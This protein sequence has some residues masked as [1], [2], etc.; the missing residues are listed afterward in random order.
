MQYVGPEAGLTGF[1]AQL[2]DTLA[3]GPLTHIFPELS[4]PPVFHLQA[5][6]KLLYV[7][8]TV[9]RGIIHAK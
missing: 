1:K 5:G 9:R 8:A 7:R 3:V 6:I 4:D 2:R